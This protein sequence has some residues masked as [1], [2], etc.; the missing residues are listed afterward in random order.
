M[1]SPYD[2][3]YHMGNMGVVT[4]RTGWTSKPQA[5]EILG[6]ILDWLRDQQAAL[7][8]DLAA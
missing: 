2:L 8:P 4:H 7:G 3:P 1:D 5:A 6:S